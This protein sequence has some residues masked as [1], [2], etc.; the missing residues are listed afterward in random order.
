MRRRRASVSG[1][2]RNLFL[3]ATDCG[4]ARTF[5]IHPFLAFM[6]F[7]FVGLIYDPI[8]PL[9]AVCLSLVCSEFSMFSSELVFFSMM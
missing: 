6:F 8:V 4:T 3:F 9:W 2:W 5:F 1:R 7:S